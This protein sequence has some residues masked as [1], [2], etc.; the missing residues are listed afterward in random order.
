MSKSV[1]FAF[2]TFIL[3]V[4][5]NRTLIAAEAGSEERAIRRAAKAFSEAYDQG[6]ADAVAAH[7][8]KDGEYTIG[9]QTV[10]GRDAIAKLYG[11]FL[12]AHP[13]SKMDIKI[14]S[15]RVLAPTVAIEQGTAAVNN[16][17]NGPASASSYSA[18]HVKQGDKWLM[19]SVRESEIP[20]IQVDRDLKELDWMIGKWSAGKDG[21]R[22]TLAC[23]WMANKHFLHADIAVRGKGGELPG[24]TQIIGRDP[25]SGK[26]VSWFFS[27]D[28]GYGTGMWQKDGSRWMIQTIGMTGDGT[29]T[30]AT[31]VLYRADKN[32]ASWQSFNRFRGDTPLPNVKE[33]V[34]DRVSGGNATSQ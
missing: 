27:A 31:N 8:T 34:L 33:V 11:A 13:G 29:P 23:D 4:A 3:S 28:G 14:D 15:I 10:K 24:G 1:F 30:T 21:S 19:V 2:A 32:V 17:A 5:C 22:A 12:R 18:V 20:S 6:N 7:W 25:A 16:S 26:I 9:Q